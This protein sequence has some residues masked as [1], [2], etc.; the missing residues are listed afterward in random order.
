MTSPDLTILVTPAPEPESSFLAPAHLKSSW[1]PD[2]VRDDMRWKN[3]LS[4]TGFGWQG[5]VMSDAVIP[6]LAAPCVNF[7]EWAESRGNPGFG[8]RLG[9]FQPCQ[10]RHLQEGLGG[11]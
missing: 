9:R 5:F 6:W 10:L 3:G 8:R 1:I 7:A 2:Q 11:P 4:Y